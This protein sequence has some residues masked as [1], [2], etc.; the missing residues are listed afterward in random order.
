MNAGRRAEDEEPQRGGGGGEE[1]RPQNPAT[2]ATKHLIL[3]R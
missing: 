3:F 1:V 2:T